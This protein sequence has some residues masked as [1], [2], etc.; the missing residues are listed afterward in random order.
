[1]NKSIL[2]FL[3]I[4]LQT[5]FIGNVYAQTESTPTSESIP[6]S[7]VETTTQNKT[8]VTPMGVSTPFTVTPTQQPTTINIL[9]TQEIPIIPTTQVPIT[10]TQEVPIATELVIVPVTIEITPTQEI[11]ITSNQITATTSA[12]ISIRNNELFIVTDGEEQIINILPHEVPT[13]T[14]QELG[15]ISIE[16]IELKSE[17]ELVP[18]YEI[19]VTQDVQLFFVFPVEISMQVE[20]DASNG[21]VISVHKPWWSFLTSQKVNIER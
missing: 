5:I 13:I 18:T 17:G 8:P 16:T 3:F 9:I 15:V 6:V 10:P 7:V 14:E 4:L 12:P 11:T 19:N 20:I 1:M 2:L 21:N